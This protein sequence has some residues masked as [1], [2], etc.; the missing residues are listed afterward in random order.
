LEQGSRPECTTTTTPIA[1]TNQST[2]QDQCSS[3]PHSAGWGSWWNPERHVSE[4]PSLEGAA[5]TRTRDWN[6]LYHLGGNGPWVEKVDNVVEGGLAP[7]AGCKVEQV[8]MVC[9]DL[10]MYFNSY[11]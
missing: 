11:R 4:S 3:T 6:I 7:P 5:G 10:L 1:T 9:S 2:V 8:H